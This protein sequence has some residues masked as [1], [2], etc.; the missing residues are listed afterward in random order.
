MPNEGFETPKVVENR[1]VS[2]GDL[3]A[4]ILDSVDTEVRPTIMDFHWLQEGATEEDFLKWIEREIDIDAEL[5]EE[6][7]KS[8]ESALA[9]SNLN[10]AY[11]QA[12]F[13]LEKTLKYDPKE[14]AVGPKSIASK[15]D[16]FELLSKTVLAKGVV[17]MS[18][19]ILYCR[20]AKATIAFHE[21]FK[22]DALE[23]KTMT[24]EFEKALVDSVGKGTPLIFVGNDE[25]GT[26]FY[27]AKDTNIS[28]VIF[29]RGKDMQSVAL[30]FLNRPESN[31]KAAL[32]DGIA[33]RFFLEKDDAKKLIPIIT[34]WLKENMKVGIV[35]MENQSFF[36]EEEM[37]KF[38]I[39]LEKTVP[40][41]GFN[42][43]N[44]S[45]NAA[46]GKE[47]QVFKLTGILKQIP[48][49][50]AESNS[51]HARQFE[52]Q[53]VVPGNA[54]EKGAMDHS[55]YTVAKL[56]AARTRLD[57][58]CPEEA[59]ME[60]VQDAHEKSR[61]PV[62]SIIHYLTEYPSPDEA[63]IAKIKKQNGKFLFVSRSVYERWQNFGFVDSKFVKEMEG[64]TED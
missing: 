40:D 21:T 46:S 35:N 31:A 14:V 5:I 58:G 10:Q 33:S 39:S 36:T 28:G 18:R 43:K 49:S 20:L 12:K 44:E 27:S 30:R 3:K 7:G 8:P 17:G 38:T 53:F 63:R 37:E 60:F 4:G 16:L 55:I 47:F 34:Q 64:G 22:H 13:F 25:E 52:M 11:Q 62:E 59:F 57:G 29:S 50:S 24:S 61:K 32:K 54:N 9:Y 19:A 23:L 26:R 45:P 56:V 1:D 15:K 6:D 2:L 42:I 51:Q 48:N 41:N